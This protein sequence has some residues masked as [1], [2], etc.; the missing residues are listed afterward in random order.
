M[1]KAITGAVAGAAATVPM[2]IF[3]EVLHARL[4][5]EPPRP[6]PPREVAEG[7]AVKAGISRELSET[8]MQRLA[9][10]LHFGYGTVTGALFGTVAPRRPAAA[11]GAGMLFGLGVWTASYLGWLPASGIRHSPRWDPPT[12]TRLLVASHLVWGAAAGLIVSLAGTARRAP[13]STRDRAR[14]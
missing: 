7:L 10:A 8:Q 1:H 6:L 2:T 13:A 4:P 11:V 9:M 12:R 5:G 3:W 14:A